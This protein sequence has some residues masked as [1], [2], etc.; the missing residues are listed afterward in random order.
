M[1][2]FVHRTCMAW[3]ISNFA[4]CTRWKTT[5]MW[6]DLIGAVFGALLVLGSSGA[7][8]RGAIG[9]TVLSPKGPPKGQQAR[10]R[11]WRYSGGAGRGG[12]PGHCGLGPPG[13]L[14]LGRDA[15]AFGTLHAAFHGQDSST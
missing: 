3:Q 9:S 5:Y 13:H 6:G 12:E 8:P 14:E 7:N 1:G 10:R 2:P 4:Y 15:R 11:A